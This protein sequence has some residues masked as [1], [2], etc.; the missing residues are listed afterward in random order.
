MLGRIL[1]WLGR[2]DWRGPWRS[3]ITHALGDGIVVYRPCQR[4]GCTVREW[5]WEK[6]HKPAVR[7]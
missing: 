1:C 4:S 3:Q 7:A 6:N 2:H 5:N